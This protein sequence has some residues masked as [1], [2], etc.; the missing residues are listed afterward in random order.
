MI[1]KNGHLFFE[2]NLYISPTGKKECTTCRKIQRKRYYKNHKRRINKKR[3]EVYKENPEYFKLK[4]AQYRKDNVE[5]IKEYDHLRYKNNPETSKEKRHR[6]KARILNQLGTVDNH[7]QKKLLASQKGKCFYC[8]KTLRE[9]GIHLEHK[10]PL[11]RGGMHDNSNL[12]LSCPSCNLR[13]GIKTEE[14]FKTSLSENKT[15]A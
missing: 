14:Q 9:T 2:N 10:T 13:K 12:C 4:S 6:R 1:C 3:Q 5:K 15:S 8:K 11:C 7:I